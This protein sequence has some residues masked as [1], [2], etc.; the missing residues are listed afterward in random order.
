MYS[1]EKIIDTMKGL[2][3]EVKDIKPYV[4]I[5]QP[6]RSKKETPIQHFQLEKG[7]CSIDMAGYSFN[8]VDID[9]EK[10]DVARNYLMDVCVESSAKYMLFVG[11]DTALPW[12]AFSKLHETAEANPD[13]IVVG[14]Y[15][16]RFSNPMI[17]IKEDNGIVRPANVDP[18]QVFEAWQ[19]G[20][21]CM[22][23]PI[24]VL[25][26]L[27]DEDPEIP[28]CCIG[29]G[30][31]GL[32]FFIGEDNFFQYRARKNGIKTLVNT[33]VQ[34]L[35]VDLATGKYT[36]H[37]SVDLDDYITAI[38][39]TETLQIKDRKFIDK[40]W[41]DRVPEGT[42]GLSA[43][44]KMRK[45][46]GLPAKICY[47]Y[48][49]TKREDYINVNL[50]YAHEDIDDISLND[51]SIDEIL[52]LHIVNYIEHDKIHTAIGELHRILKPGGKLIFEQLDL[53]KT[54][55]D[56][57]SSRPEDKDFIT[58]YLFNNFS[59]SKI[60]AVNAYYP[61]RLKEILLDFGFKDIQISEI[62]DPSVPGCNFRIEGT[63]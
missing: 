50:V 14:V 55:S 35:H 24:S 19:T 17:I 5:A 46:N 59:N 9:G 30:L 56:F 25:K 16:F 29:Y 54:C 20:M 62:E 39:V 49:E 57:L 15:Y 3:E 41:I 58:T 53:E 2:A 4:I 31:E 6:R 60:K 10:V 27:K 36:A 52:G 11:E 47:S 63:K 51:Q 26:K 40:R 1:R 33:D 44:L 48:I 42:G 61:E 34:C 8:F 43:Q 23:I 28:F 21:D 18:G 38:D 45:D 22:L 13:S 7:Q 32:P 12:Y 37:P